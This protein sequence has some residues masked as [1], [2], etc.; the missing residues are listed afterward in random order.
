MDFHAKKICSFVTNYA[1]YDQQTAKVWCIW[2]QC[3]LRKSYYTI[4]R[5]TLTWWIVY[6]CNPYASSIT[7]SYPIV[8]CQCTVQG[9]CN[10]IN[11]YAH[12]KYTY[13]IAYSKLVLNFICLLHSYTCLLYTRDNPLSYITS[14][15]KLHVTSV[16]STWTCHSLHVMQLNLP[17][18]SRLCFNYSKITGCIL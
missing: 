4:E 13:L 15:C 3:K 5:F 9:W 2:S 12:L 1:L 11:N 16:W 17:V 18:L 14:K 8:Q 7:I 10:Q 6:F